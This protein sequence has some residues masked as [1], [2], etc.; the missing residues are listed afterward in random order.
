LLSLHGPSLT[1]VRSL[2]ACP[3][4]NIGTE[5]SK[6]KTRSLHLHLY[7]FS[8]LPHV[9]SLI[10]RL[11]LLSQQAPAPVVKPTYSAP[12]QTVDPFPHADVSKLQCL[13]C[14]RQFKELDT[15]QKHNNSS[16]LHKAN[17]FMLFSRSSLLK[18]LPWNR[19][20]CKILP[21]SSRLFSAKPPWHNQS[22]STARSFSTV[23]ELQNAALPWDNPIGPS[24]NSR[25]LA[26]AVV[27]NLLNLSFNPTEKA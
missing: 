10:P 12:A 27:L 4:S 16:D 19:R 23:T 17:P 14:Q 22:K 6:I 5:S 20:I 2:R 15:L 18:S 1:F 11:A 24:W 25:R 7:S 26:N 3:R 21:R 8:S 13:L 9:H